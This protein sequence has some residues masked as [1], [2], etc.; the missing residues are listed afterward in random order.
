MTKSIYNI[1][2]RRGMIVIIGVLLTI[3]IYMFIYR[4]INTT[5]STKQT[6]TIDSIAQEL[7]LQV[8]ASKKSTTK[9]ESTPR[10]KKTTKVQK[11][12]KYIERDPLNELLPTE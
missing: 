2:E 10:K 6:A 4:T 3:V 9:K 1:G 7:Q 11:K 8:E 12:N 5:D